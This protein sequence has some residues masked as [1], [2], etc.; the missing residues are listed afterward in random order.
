[1]QS[2]P[3]GLPVSTFNCTQPFRYPIISGILIDDFTE[4]R[5][6]TSFEAAG[7]SQGTPESNKAGLRILEKYPVSRDIITSY[8]HEFANQ[9]LGY[10]NEFMITTSWTTRLKKGDIIHEH[11]HANSFYSGVF[12]HGETYGDPPDGMLWFKNPIRDQARYEFEADRENYVD[13]DFSIIPQPN[14]LVL[15]P[16]QIKHWVYPYNGKEDRVSLAFNIIPKGCYGI[17]DSYI[18]TKWIQ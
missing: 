16:S 1:M 3:A 5:S 11:N 15:F 13:H 10:K 6:D 4:L 17:G 2:P 9:F 8:L 7:Q 14:L 18:D 12:Y